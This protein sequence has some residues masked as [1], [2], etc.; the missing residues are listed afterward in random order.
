MLFLY[1]THNSATTESSFHGRWIVV[2]SAHVVLYIYTYFSVTHT[3]SLLLL[4]KKVFFSMF[5]VLLASKSLF[6]FCVYYFLTSIFRQHAAIGM[7]KDWT[8]WC[9]NGGHQKNAWKKSPR[10]RI[11]SKKWACNNHVSLLNLNLIL[12]IW[13]HHPVNEKMVCMHSKRES[14]RSRI[15]QLLLKSVVKKSGHM[16]SFRP[17]KYS[18]LYLVGTT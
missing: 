6:F 3:Q 11:V 12:A 15:Q 10:E 13:P 4:S 7:S 14:G 2:D 16:Y 9:C 1:P 8:V 17:R 5:P 18:L